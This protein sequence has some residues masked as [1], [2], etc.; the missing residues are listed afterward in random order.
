MKTRTRNLR[1]AFA[2]TEH[3]QGKH[4]LIVD[5]VMTTG[6]SMH[7]LAHVIKRAGARQVT[8]VVL[9]RTLKETSD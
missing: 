6:A 9:A 2:T 3:W 1:R 5:D 8:A 4:V 7:A